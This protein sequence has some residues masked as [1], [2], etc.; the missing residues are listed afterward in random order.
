VKSEKARRFL[1]HNWSTF[2]KKYLTVV[3]G[4]LQQK[5]GVIRSY[6]LENKEHSVYVAF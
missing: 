2:S 6:I 3:H 4:K 5:E 1:H